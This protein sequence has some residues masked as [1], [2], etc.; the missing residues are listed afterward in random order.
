V[1]AAFRAGTLERLEGQRIH[2]HGLERSLIGQALRRLDDP[3]AWLDTPHPVLAGRTPDATLLAGE[4]ELV[5]ALALAESQ[6]TA[7]EPSGF[8]PTSA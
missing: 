6:E 4:Y 7:A 5:S 8:L 3:E 2:D 1:A